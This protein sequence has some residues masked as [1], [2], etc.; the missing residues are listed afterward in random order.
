MKKKAL[1]ALLSASMVLSAVGCGNKAVEPTVSE[2]TIVSEVEEEPEDTTDYLALDIKE[3]AGDLNLTDEI[4]SQLSSKIK[5]ITESDDTNITEVTLADDVINDDPNRIFFRVILEDG[6]EIL[7]EYAPLSDYSRLLSYRASGYMIQSDIVDSIYDDYCAITDVS[8][9]I[10]HKYSN[11][12]EIFDSIYVPGENTLYSETGMDLSLGMLENGTTSKLLSQIE[13]YYGFSLE[14]KRTRDNELIRAYES[15][16]NNVNMTFVNGLYSDTTIPLVD[17]Y[18]KDAEEVYHSNIKN[19]DFAA[20]GSPALVNDYF[21]SKSESLGDIITAETLFSNK[22]ILLS[23]FDFS[24]SWV[25][26]VGSENEVEVVFNRVDGKKIVTNGINSVETVYY[27]NSYATGFEKFYEGYNISFIG[28]LPDESICDENGDF[29]LSDIDLT[30]FLASK[31]TDTTV[32]VVFPQFTVESKSSL[33]DGMA[34]VGAE[35]IFELG[36]AGNYSKMCTANMSITDVIQKNAI[37]IGTT[38]SS[39]AAANAVGSATEST[40][41]LNRPFA[42]IIYDET[43]DEIL[44]L[45]K[46]VTL[47]GEEYEEK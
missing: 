25:N 17:T 1:L 18:V 43:N 42:F 9:R 35:S 11:A 37:T 26:Y 39:T 27:A 33:K 44:L 41:S 2:D 6:G 10:N 31:T 47:D 30:S 3:L 24:G 19:I 23:G 36:D 15:Y 28:I 22:S 8:R 13:T 7:V 5:L 21:T 16:E 34:S 40:V 4:C 38:S 46:I 32:N 29:E 45:G 14:A 20:E 12:T